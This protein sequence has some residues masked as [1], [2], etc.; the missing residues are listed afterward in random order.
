M[1]FKLHFIFYSGIPISLLRMLQ[2]DQ[3][4]ITIDSNVLVKIQCMLQ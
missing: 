4:S 2:T 1:C 3:Q